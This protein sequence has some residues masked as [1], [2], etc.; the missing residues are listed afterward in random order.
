MKREENPDRLLLI[1]RV[2]IADRNLEE[3]VSVVDQKWHSL[4]G[5]GKRTVTEAE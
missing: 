4:A 3:R 5:Q 1:T 2:D